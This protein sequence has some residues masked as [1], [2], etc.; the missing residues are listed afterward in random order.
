MGTRHPGLT[1][2]LL[3][4]LLK[5]AARAPRYRIVTATIIGTITGLD[6]HEEWIA[7]DQMPINAALST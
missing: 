5:T 3:L 6:Q 2:P 7:L 4:V 1:K